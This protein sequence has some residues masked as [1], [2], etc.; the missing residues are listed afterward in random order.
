AEAE[1][2]FHLAAPPAQTEGVIDP[3]AAHHAGSTGTLHVL[4]AARDANVKRVLYASS[5]YVYGERSGAPGR[6]AEPLQPLC[7]YG[8]AKQM[9]EQQCL[10]FTGQYGLETVRLRYFSV[11][12]PR[13]SADSPYSATL[14]Q[15][16]R[17]ALAGRRAV[18]PGGPMG[19]QDLLAVDDAVHATLLAAGTRRAGG[20]G[21][22]IGAGR[23]R[24]VP[25]A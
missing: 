11:F 23:F 2:V 24:T 25:H 21:D 16:I 3:M 20:R 12:G 14:A 8:L 1:Y 17:Q 6:G 13:Q 19:Q 9:G 18:I 5:C 7:P 10:A 4:M 15:L 22:N